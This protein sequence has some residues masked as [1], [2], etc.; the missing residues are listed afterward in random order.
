MK[1]KRPAFAR[2]ARIYRMLL[3]LYPRDHRREYGGLMLQLFRD[4]CREAY[5][6][7]GTRGLFGV[8]RCVPGDLIFSTVKEH[9]NNLKHH[10]KTRSIHRLTQILFA[11]AVALAV[12]SNPTAVGNTLAVGFLYLSTLA[13]LA[14]AIVDW[15]RP[16]ADW[17]KGLIWGFVVLVAYALIMPFWAKLHMIHRNAFP[18]VSALHVVAIFLNM[19]VPVVRAVLVWV[20]R[21]V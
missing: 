14:R 8:W 18:M 5:E 9:L 13:I 16:P 2:T 21:A 19:I 10:V 4:Q 7:R 3:W 6:E 17:V 11:V 1:P 15:F 12:L 20:G